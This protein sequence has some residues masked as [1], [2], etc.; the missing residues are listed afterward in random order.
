VICLKGAEGGRKGKGER[1]KPRNY[2]DNL[3]IQFSE[4]LKGWG[5]LQKLFEKLS[6][7]QLDKLYFMTFEQPLNQVQLLRKIMN[8]VEVCS[9]KKK[10]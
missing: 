9:T 8:G 4:Y 3:T 1:G 10:R 5:L 2:S 6:P 7:R